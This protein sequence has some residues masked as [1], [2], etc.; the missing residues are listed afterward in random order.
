MTESVGLTFIK[1][2]SHIKK[3]THSKELSYYNRNTHHR[4]GKLITTLIMEHSYKKE[5]I[6][7]NTHILKKKEHS[8]NGTLIK[9]NTHPGIGTLILK[10][11]T[12]SK[13]LSY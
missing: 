7:R 3:G 13:E 12:H 11:N 1:R 8:S 10:R 6:Q 4:I 5:L 2:N 9:W